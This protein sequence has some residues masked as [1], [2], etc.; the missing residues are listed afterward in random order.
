MGEVGGG[1]QLCLLPAH[2]EL[3]QL[4]Y[5]ANSSAVQ[6]AHICHTQAG[7]AVISGIHSALYGAGG[8][9]SC[10]RLH[11][12]PGNGSGGNLGARK[13]RICCISRGIARLPLCGRSSCAH[14]QDQ[15]RIRRRRCVH[16]ALPSAWFCSGV[17]RR[18]KGSGCQGAC[19]AGWNTFRSPWGARPVC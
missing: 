3:S 6:A 11:S 15:T 8:P 13:R 16:P 1:E 2:E 14:K 10:I 9:Q 12:H 7:S 4:D 17:W 19:S 18:W 5:P